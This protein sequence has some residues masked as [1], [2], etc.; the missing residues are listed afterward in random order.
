MQR[1]DSN[2]PLGEQFQA[3]QR[4]SIY[5]AIAIPAIMLLAVYLAFAIEPRYRATGTIMLEQTTIPDDLIRTTVATYADQQIEIVRR[6]VLT[7]S[8]LKELVREVDPY[9]DRPD[10]TAD[11]KADLISENTEIERVD[12]VTLKTLDESTAFSIHYHNPDPQRARDVADELVDMFLTYNQRTRTER[13]SETFEFLNVRSRELGESIREMEQRLAKFKGQYG[14]ALP[15]A[16]GRNLA[17]LDQTQRDLDGVMRQLRM[18]Q[19]QESIL[20]LQLR[21]ISPSMSAPVGDW[22]MELA[23]LK[24]ELAAAEQRYTEDHPDVRRLRRAIADLAAAGSSTESA[25]TGS[26]DNP[27][28]LRVKSQLDA[29]QREIA[30]LSAS[31]SRARGQIARYSGQIR[32]APNVEREYAQLSREYAIGQDQFRDIQEKLR[33]ASIARALESQQRGERFALIRSPS[34][35]GSPHSPNRLGI[36]LLG[37]V[38]SIGISA[39]LVAFVESADPTVRGSRDVRALTSL[40]LISAVPIM[41]TSRD[42][43]VRTLAWTSASIAVLVAAALVAYTVISAV[44]PSG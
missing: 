20:Q 41:R 33:D 40:P 10:L 35:P 11:D 36:I 2:R 17:S 15:E 6:R 18:A 13:A 23:K 25:A 19:E 14:D 30:A 8:T 1:D 44:G 32:M 5:P 24:A 12:P 38:L 26:P 16:Q 34:V 21:Q 9:P 7:N 28:Y 42:Q 43:R 27:D 29:T 37:L 4:R 39:G 22:R 3:L 31:A